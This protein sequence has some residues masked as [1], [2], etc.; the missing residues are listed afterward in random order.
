MKPVPCRGCGA[1][2]VFAHGPNGLI[3]LDTRA[4]VYQFVE[5][6]PGQ[7]G[8]ARRAPMHFVS[9]YATCPKAREFSKGRKP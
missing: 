1:Q 5:G 6:E 4:P 7:S 8:E 2:I 9:H 3:P